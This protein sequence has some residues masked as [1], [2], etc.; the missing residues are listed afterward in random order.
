MFTSHTDNNSQ[1]KIIQKNSH[2]KIKSEMSF[3]SRISSLIYSSLNHSEA[4]QSLFFI[5]AII[6]FQII[7]KCNILFFFFDNSTSVNILA[8]H[9]L[10]LFFNS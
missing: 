1:P 2:L 4:I 8:T 9:S 6:N 5:S 3:F 10:P 7:P